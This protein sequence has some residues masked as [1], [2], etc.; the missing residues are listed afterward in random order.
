MELYCTP[1]VNTLQLNTVGNSRQHVHVR[2]ARSR[3]THSYRIL[4]T[5]PP[6]AIFQHSLQFLQ[7]ESFQTQVGTIHRRAIGPLA[8]H[9]GTS[10]YTSLTRHLP[11]PTIECLHRP[12]YKLTCSSHNFRYELSLPTSKESEAKYTRSHPTDLQTRLL[13]QLKFRIQRPTSTRSL[14]QLTSSFQIPFIS[15]RHIHSNVRPL[16]RAQQC[17]L[18]TLLSANHARPSSIVA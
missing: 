6:V 7:S 15:P 3:N 12:S 4:P 2:P 16:L 1:E 18:F 5:G 11:A 13:Y 9:N 14:T 8:L 10:A 17:C